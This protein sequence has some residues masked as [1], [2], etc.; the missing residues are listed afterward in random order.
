MCSTGNDGYSQTSGHIPVVTIFLCD[1][2]HLKYILFTKFQ[3]SEYCR[4][5]SCCTL[6]L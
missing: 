4:Q 3:C 2:W 1:Q 6:N 5:A